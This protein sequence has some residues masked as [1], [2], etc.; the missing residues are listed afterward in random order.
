MTKL[1]YLKLALANNLAN[2]LAWIFSAF[3]VTKESL[4]A[5]KEDAYAYR[6]VSS[7]AQYQFIESI[8]KEK[9]PVLVSIE[10]TTTKEPLFKFKDKVMVDKTWAPNIK[11]SVECSIGNLIFNSVCILPAFG[12]KYPFTAGKLSVGAHESYIAP[13][14]MNTPKNDDERDA[15]K[16][17][18]DEYLHFRDSLVYLEQFATITSWSATRKGIT[19]PEG[20][21]TLKKQL[22]AEYGDRLNDP[23][24]FAEYEN[25]LKAFDKE[26]LKDD[27]AYG[28][29]ITGKVLNISRKKM[30]LTYGI[31]DRLDPKDPIVPI[32]KTLEEG[33]ST[34]PVEYTAMLNGARFGSFSR[35]AETV[36]G[37]VVSKSIIRV[38]SNYEVDM[39]DCG[40]TFGITK[41][42]NKDNV[43]TLVS[44]TL[45]VNKV[46]VYVEKIED[47]EH[48]LGKS[49]VVRSPATCQAGPGDRLCK[50]CCGT[51]LSQYPTGLAIP[52]T[53]VSQLILT[54]SLKAMHGKVLS[55]SELDIELSIT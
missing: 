37:G 2:N 23:T 12:N 27:P 5:H 36:N 33:Q 19:A 40:T 30:F 53:E 52:L 34:D 24:V 32:T 48:Y 25:K 4:Q 17:Y 44:R 49:V 21:G 16:I 46:P 50:V 51:A 9:E 6:L 8:S 3:C 47:A 38:G 26:W 43:K 13:R 42:V 39:E 31:P 20:V 1:D 55:T 11:E 28:T 22:L 15:G 14:L 45:L 10:G 35:G 41:Y 7:N 54:Q 18:V 29:F